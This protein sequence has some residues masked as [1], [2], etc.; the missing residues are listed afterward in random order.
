M[1]EALMAERGIKAIANAEIIHIDSQKITLT[2]G[3]QLP[4]TYSMILPSFRGVSFIQHDLVK[5]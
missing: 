1:T 4:F 5:R 2:D 3:Y